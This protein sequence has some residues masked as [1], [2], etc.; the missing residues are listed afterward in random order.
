MREIIIVAVV[1]LLSIA[2]AN[3][4]A[5]IAGYEYKIWLQER[6][7]INESVRSAQ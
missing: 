1:A 2:T 5:I 3:A 4:G 7:E 6:E